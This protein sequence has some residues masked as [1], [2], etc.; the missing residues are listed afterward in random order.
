MANGPKFSLAPSYTGV[1]VQ[2]ALLEA[3]STPATASSATTGAACAP[4]KRACK[5]CS[6]G[7]K[8]EEEAEAPAVTVGATSEDLSKKAS[9]CGNV[10][11]VVPSF[12]SSSWDHLGVCA[13]LQRRCFPVWILSL[14]GQA[15]FQA[16]RREHNLARH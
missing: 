11:V 14:L 8:E 13:V 15:C 4:K 1:G 7:R 3:D 2:D 10:S 6:C 12:F 9:A 5:N 16:W